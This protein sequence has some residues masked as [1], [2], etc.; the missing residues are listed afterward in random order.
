MAIIFTGSK[1][2][3]KICSEIKDDLFAQSSEEEGVVVCWATWLVCTD[4]P[5]VGFRVCPNDSRVANHRWWMLCLCRRGHS[6]EYLSITSQLTA[7]SSSTR[8]I[9]DPLNYYNQSRLR[10]LNYKQRQFGWNNLCE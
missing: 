8:V 10:L 9:A 7:T 4:M 6:F 2:I 5:V 1:A 3:T